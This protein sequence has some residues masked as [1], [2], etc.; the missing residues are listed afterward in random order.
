MAKVVTQFDTKT[1][2]ANLPVESIERVRSLAKES[3]S[4]RR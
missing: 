1:W 3:F 4:N 2:L